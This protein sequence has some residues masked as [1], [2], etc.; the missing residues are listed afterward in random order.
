[1]SKQFQVDDWSFS[2]LSGIERISDTFQVIGSK[3]FGYEYKNPNPLTDE[4]REHVTQQ[5]EEKGLTVISHNSDDRS[6][7]VE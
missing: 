1:M 4:E 5:L 7:T 3:I 6:F 2:K